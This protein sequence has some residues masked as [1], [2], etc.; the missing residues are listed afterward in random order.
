[1]TGFTETI[2]YT[3]LQC[4]ECAVV[5]YFPANWCNQARKEGKDWQCPN[6]HGQW[7]GEA[8]NDKIR[9]E[10]DRLK[11]RIAEKDDQIRREQDN[12][13][14]ERRR[15][16]AHKG[17]ATRIKNRIA[18][19]A[20]P[21]CNRNFANLRRHMASQHPDYTKQEPPELVVVEGG[22]KTR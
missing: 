8:E 9:R 1:M 12:A 21:C 5:Y 14:F 22:K 17:H 2:D 11:Q 20:C 13:D 4:S 6:G 10:R 7:Y 18:G 3:R 19:G 16:R 15:A